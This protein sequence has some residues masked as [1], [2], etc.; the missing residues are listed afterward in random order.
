[1]FSRRSSINKNKTIVIA[2]VQ[3]LMLEKR[4]RQYRQQR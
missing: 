2:A 4:D 1:M 3:S